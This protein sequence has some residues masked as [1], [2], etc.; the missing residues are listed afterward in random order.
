MYPEIQQAAER[1]EWLCDRIP[2]LLLQ[3][4][5]ATFAATPVPGKWSRKE[6]IGHLVDSAAN[7]H[8]RFVRGQFED[9]PFIVYDQNAWNAHGY[10]NRIDSRQLIGFWESYNRQ[11]AALIRCIPDELL[12]RTVRT[13]QPRTLAFLITDYVAHQEHHLRQVI[14]Y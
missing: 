8:H 1:L 12:T 10:Y 9:A 4:P 13:D 3:L 2:S 7:N 14:N 11:L 6:I 5:E